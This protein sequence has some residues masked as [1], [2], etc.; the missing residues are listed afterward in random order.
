MKAT[1][2]KFEVEKF[3]GKGDFGLWKCKMLCQIEIVGLGSVLKEETSSTDVEGEE[4]KDTKPNPKEQDWELR[5]KNLISMFLSDL[6]LRKRYAGFRTE[7]LDVFLKL[8]VDLASL[9]I[10]INEEDL[11][12]QILTSL[13]KQYES[14]VDA[15]KYG[16][17]K[18]TLT[19]RDFTS[20]A[21]SK[22]VELREKGLLNKSKG[23]SEGLFAGDNRGRGERKNDKT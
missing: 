15:L 14:L 23:N 10:K 19:V 20:S 8:V 9:D 13:S 6:I 2:G 16:S 12:I 18:E 21:Y 11:V 7:I 3:D 22:E 1:S 17:R 4:Q 5:T